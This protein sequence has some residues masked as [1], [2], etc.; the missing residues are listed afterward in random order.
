MAA[1]IV[2]GPTLAAWLGVSRTRIP[3]L[4]ASGI[5]VR[6]GRGKFDLKC[7]VQAYC[8]HQHKMLSHRD[9]ESRAARAA[10]LMASAGFKTATANRRTAIIK[11]AESWIRGADVVEQW[12]RIARELR[13]GFDGLPVRLQSCLPNL[14]PD[15]IEALEDGVR[16]AL[17]EMADRLDPLDEKE[18]A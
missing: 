18:A 9:D 7:S 11:D 5:L 4:A 14:T 15:D 13:H 1:T 16:K 3:E 6:T 12:A 10:S 8:E 2:N 17:N